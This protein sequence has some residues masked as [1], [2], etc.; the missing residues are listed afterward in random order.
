MGENADH[1]SA[2]W[3]V[4]EHLVLEQAKLSV[5]GLITPSSGSAQRRVLADF[6]LNG[7]RDNGELLSCCLHRQRRR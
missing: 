2:S 3:S 4:V 7:C 1:A 6:V 5:Q